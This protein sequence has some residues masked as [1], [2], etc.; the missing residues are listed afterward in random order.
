MVNQ[1]S[2]RFFNE[3]VHS[4]RRIR[5]ETSL[6]IHKDGTISGISSHNSKE[7]YETFTIV[8]AFLPF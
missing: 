5:P 6:E 7:I 1:V 8:N 3:N 2:S 4:S